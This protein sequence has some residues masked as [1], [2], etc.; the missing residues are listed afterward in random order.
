M[1]LNRMRVG[2]N[3]NQ[4]IVYQ[5]NETVHLYVRDKYEKLNEHC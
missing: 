2:M 1:F 5:P 4:N 3:E